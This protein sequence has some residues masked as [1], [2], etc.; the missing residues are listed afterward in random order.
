MRHV[1]TVCALSILSLS[2]VRC[3]GD[4][5]RAES[6]STVYGE[7]PAS[8]ATT[9]EQSEPEMAPA[10]GMATAEPAPPPAEQS[11]SLSD[12]QI[13]AIS[14]AL[15]AAE[16]AH[17]RIAL[18][19]AKN[20]RVRQFAQKMVDHHEKARQDQMRLVTQ[21]GLIPRDN[22]KVVELRSD[23]L[24]MEE[25][26]RSASTNDFDEKYIDGQIEMHEKALEK[27]DQELIPNARSAE[28]R[29][30]LTDLR[31]RIASHLA[32]AREIGATLEGG[33]SGRGGAKSGTGTSGTSP[34]SR[35]TTP[36][37]S[38]SGS[39]TGS[40]SGSTGSGSQTSPGGSGSSSGSGS[41][42]GSGT[43]PSGG[44]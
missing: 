5:R 13:A 6:P 31:A 44:R 2:L 12:E 16:V 4:D 11:P 24:Q 18:S 35:G 17:A 15:N 42:A 32:E 40:G 29:Q 33:S 21:L 36:A 9:V 8:G 38:G 30:L 43:N 14:D 10:S 20:R 23:A 19:K 26:L 22:E 28:L 34:S 7:A 41:K 1:G 25:E 27:L 39:A 3:G 37:G